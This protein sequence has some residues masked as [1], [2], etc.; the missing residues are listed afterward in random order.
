MKKLT[1]YILPLITIMFL[2]ALLPGWKMPCSGATRHPPTLTPR[3]R[4]WRL[5]PIP[6][7][8]RAHFSQI[9]YLDIA[10]PPFVFGLKARLLLSVLR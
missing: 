6:D 4:V 5:L 2:M 3:S 7:A 8:K 9:Q 1:S 10:Q